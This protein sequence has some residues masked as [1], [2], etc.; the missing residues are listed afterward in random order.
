LRLLYGACDVFVT[1]PWYE[2]FGITPVEAMACGRPVIG[3]RVGGIA[4]TVSNGRTGYL[5]P[6]CD[7]DALAARL[8]QLHADPAL[9][10]RM[11]AAARQ[12]ARRFYT[13]AKV[14]SGLLEVY[15]KAG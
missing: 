7:P 9:C 13:W 12:R 4:H 10:R 3:A 2:P 8:A 14:G 6:P 11:G 1:T 15:R 5:V